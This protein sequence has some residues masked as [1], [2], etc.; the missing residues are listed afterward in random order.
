[1]LAS[2]GFFC[3]NYIDDFLVLADDLE[4][5]RAGLDCLVSLVQSLGLEIN[6]EKVVGPHTDLVFLGVH[7][8]CVSRVLSLPAKKLAEIKVLLAT[9]E[10]KEKVTKKS[11]QSLVGKLNWAARVVLGGVLFYAI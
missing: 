3:L 1:M 4:T 6:W 2:K 11:L 7:V 10:F 5:C 8:D 9:W